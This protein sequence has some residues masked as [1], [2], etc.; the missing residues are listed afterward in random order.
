MT[1]M[2]SRRTGVGSASPVPLTFSR[3]ALCVL[4]GHLSATAVFCQPTNL[5]F[6]NQTIA[7]GTYQATNSI[8]ADAGNGSATTTIA[9]GA[10]VIFQAGTKI[11]L[12]PDFH[13]FPGS[14]FQ[15]SIGLGGSGFT[16]SGKVT[17]P[18]GCG[19]SGVTVNLTGA[20][21]GSTKTGATGA[22]AFTVASGSGS[23]T[24]QPSQP[25]FTFNYSSLSVSSSNPTAS[26]QVT[27]PAIPA[28]EYVRLG[29]RIV[30]VAN[31]GA[32]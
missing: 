30:A 8:T 13:A 9:S 31:C 16:I 28:R 25:G 10:S 27:S 29:G 5:T 18:S 11:A 2:V 24:V 12:L 15:A 1:Q 4:A 20:Q 6:T 21:N 32:Q 3:V 17:A 22:Y 19:I 23:Y 7:S 14:S 26:F